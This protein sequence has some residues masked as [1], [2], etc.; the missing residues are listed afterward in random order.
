[1][2]FCVP[3]AQA[4]EGPL[5][6][7]LCMPHSARR[8]WVVELAIRVHPLPSRCQFAGSNCA[9]VNWTTAPIGGV[10]AVGVLLHEL[11]HEV[12]NMDHWAG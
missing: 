4:S 12:Y 9:P 10:D 11:G 7:M 5:P 8:C 6:P 2:V 3:T 1:M